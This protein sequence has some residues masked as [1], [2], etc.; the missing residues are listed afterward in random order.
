MPFDLTGSL[1]NV[2]SGLADIGLHETQQ[3]IAEMNI[4][5]G[6]LQ[7]AGYDVGQVE[8]EVGIPPKMNITLKPGPAVSEEKLNLV[9]KAQSGSTM[10]TAVV[11]SLIAA[12]QLRSGIHVEDLSMSEITIEVAAKPKLVMS[13]KETRAA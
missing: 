6:A 12:N 3:A 2:A 8:I 1:K 13:W 9:L 10:T 7:Q 11:R 5:L 4:L